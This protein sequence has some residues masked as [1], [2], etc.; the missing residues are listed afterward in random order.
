MFTDGLDKSALRWVREKEVPF[1]SSNMRSRADPITGI[2]AGTG[3]R[4]FGL[5]PPSKFRSGHLPGSAIPVS[6]TISGDVDNSASASENDMSTDSE[7]DVYGTRYSM[8]SSPQRNGVP[9]RSGYRYGN[10]LPGRLNNGS[11][12]FFSD[13]SSSRETLVGGHRPMAERM[14]ATNGR[15]P[16]GQNVYT[17]DDS[18]DSAAS[19]EFSTTQVGGSINGAIPRNRASMASDGYS[20]SQPSRM[21]AGNAPRKQNGRFSDDDDQDDVPS[22]PPF[23]ASSH[24]IKQCPEKCQDVKLNGA[25][26]RKTP[27]GVEL[28]NGKKSSDQ[29][30]RPVNSEAAGSSGLARLPT[31]NASALGPWYAV[32]A[33]DACV[34]LC[35][36]AWAMENMEAPTF[37]ENECAVLRDAFGLRQVLL[38]SEDEL[39]VKRTS[40]LANEG[41]PTK[42]KKTIG[43]IKVQ[44]RKVKMGLDPPTG[45]NI[46]SLKSPVVN[47]ETIKYQFSSFQSAVVSG[48]HALNKIRVA[49]RIPVNS[50]L[51]RQS[52]AYVHASTQYIKQVS[53]VLKAGV[54]TLRSSS[55]SYEVVQETYPCL[56]R[57]KSLA[58][59]DAVKM[60]A[61]SGET[62][63]FFPDGLGDDLIIEVQDSNA[64]H[65]GR[66]VLQIAAITDNP[67]EK[68]R[69]W[70]IYREPEHELVGKIQLYVNYSA[71]TD[72]SQPKCGLVAE[73]VAYD[74]VLEVAMKVQ[75]FQQRNLLLHGSWKWLLTEFASYY[76]ISEVYTRLRYLSYIMDVATPTADCL[77]L[78]HDLLMPVVMKGHDKSTLSHQENR[79]LGETRVQIEQ[80]LALVFEN[81]KSLDEAALSG[82]ME[83]YR[84]ATGVA[85]PAIE[86]AVKLYTL[87]HDILSPEAQTS[88]CHYFQ[89][90]VKKRSRR[91]LSET[92]EYMGNNNE[93]S[94][95]DNVTMSTAYQK[96]KSV[97]LNIREEILSDI[98]IHNQHI[99]PSFVDLPN[100]SA[101]IY[102]TELCTRLRSFL[103]ACPP[104][105]PS[106]AVAELV[107]ATAD[108]QRDLARWSISPVKGG[109]DA[110]ELFHLYILV[111]IQDKRLLLLET[112][113]LDK[114][115]WSGVRTQHSTTPF[116]DEMY[117]RL[118]E[119]LSDFEI[120][121]CRW[122]EYTF[123]LEQAIADVEKALVEALDKQYA[124]VLA[125]LK[126]NLAPKKFG[127]KYVQKLAKRTPSSYTVPDELGILL[128]SMKRML[129]VLRPKIEAQFKQWGSCIPEGGNVIPGERLSEVTVMLRAKFRNYLQAI[130]EKFVENTKL[131]NATKL[132][133]IL[134]DSKEAVIESEIR[135]RMQPLKDQLANTINQI[136][137]VFESRVFIAICRGY[138]DRM[139]RDVLSFMENRKENRSWYRGSRIAVSVLDDTFASQMQQLLGNSL[140]EKDLEPPTSITE[141]RSMLCKD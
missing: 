99:L 17:E 117:D 113:R 108:F 25:D 110:K 44:V 91:H 16:T 71:S 42:P 48:W 10:H 126:E 127:L 83:V 43:K 97:C 135:S 77:T 125:P 109:V 141:V 9:N 30:V 53:K 139:G 27:S 90:A 140:Q 69:W 55:T 64:K 7:E 32:I 49:P 119:T 137:T 121:I 82:L 76:G 85:A 106:P 81:Y 116:V 37:L 100:L 132:K 35:L 136:H 57:L 74:L 12:Y 28:Q 67:A 46:L 26:D 86:P 14:R 89:V 78:V 134:Q 29:F 54:T 50:S 13:V 96:M 118:K 3:A 93:G 21:N 51:S 63:V 130:V 24:E 31:Y 61:G 73:T 112:C 68:L 138:W 105:G 2:R 72:D 122:P 124:D 11:D 102:S 129:D 58:E 36:H 80:T 87:L 56:L 65:I 33:Y 95:V 59:E 98:E 131:Q 38:Q 1:G 18:S 88:L 84:P 4:G 22:A 5:P 114:V 101:S 34:R 123:V 19:S 20:S 41:A 79:I 60:Q 103:I 92:D 8:D 52:M 70:S 111:W 6:R 133:K 75:H 15:F 39:L 23:C 40:E 66:A 104:T 45:C 94:L 120:F 115:K 62:H 128:N 107:I 47:L